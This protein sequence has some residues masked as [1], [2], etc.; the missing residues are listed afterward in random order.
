M[1]LIHGVTLIFTLNSSGR[2][3]AAR[4]FSK[5]SGLVSLLG[6]Y[7]LLHIED[8]AFS[9]VLEVMEECPIRQTQPPQPH[10]IYNLS[11]KN[12]LLGRFGGAGDGIRTRDIQLGRL[13]LYQLS[14]SRM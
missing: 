5:K 9:L 3:S 4:Q 8:I 10:N 12:R 1:N 2:N 6:G 11:Q 13:T 14:Y 7:G